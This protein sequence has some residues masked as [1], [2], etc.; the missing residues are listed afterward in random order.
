V[1]YWSNW[2]QNVLFIICS[3]VY[4]FT[5]AIIENVYFS[6]NNKLVFF[7]IFLIWFNNLNRYSA[8]MKTRCNTNEFN[9]QKLLLLLLTLHNY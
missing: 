8:A 9:Q 2:I 5:V 6:A 7:L 3:L 4:I 1:N